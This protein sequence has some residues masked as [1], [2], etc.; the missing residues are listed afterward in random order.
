MIMTITV[1]VII[2]T[3]IVVVIAIIFEVIIII[4][5]WRTPVPSQSARKASPMQET[6][7][8]RARTF[9]SIFGN[10]SQNLYQEPYVNINTILV[11]LLFIFVPLTQANCWNLELTCTA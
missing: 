5:T 2:I 8:P 6:P 10:F 11:F 4:L 1:T 9:L 3:I 7:K